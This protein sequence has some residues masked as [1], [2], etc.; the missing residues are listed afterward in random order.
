MLPQ[1]HK[2]SNTGRSVVSSIGYHSTN[3][4]ISTN[5]YI[6]ISDSYMKQLHVQLKKLLNNKSCAIG[7]SLRLNGCFSRFLNCLNG[8]KSRNAPHI[9]M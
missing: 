2:T 5:H 6:P 9:F 7:D 4:Y 8:T 3:I 1:T